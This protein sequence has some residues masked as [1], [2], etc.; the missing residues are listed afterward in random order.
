MENYKI[1][2]W[3]LCHCQHINNF[4]LMIIKFSYDKCCFGWIQLNA[5]N[6]ETAGS[7]KR[8]S[9][10]QQTIHFDIQWLALWLTISWLTN[11]SPPHTIMLQI[12]N[13][14]TPN[15]SMLV[16][17]LGSDSLWCHHS[18]CL[19]KYY[20]GEKIAVNVTIDNN[21]NKKIKKIAITGM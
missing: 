19:Q 15:T 9:E 4:W 21:S 18:V 13:G 7:Q 12:L 2:H 17:L 3:Q 6:H 16:F 10:F 5:D 14:G 8:W 11:P 20:H 1:S